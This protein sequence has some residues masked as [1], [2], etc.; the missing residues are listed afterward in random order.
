MESLV[1]HHACNSSLLPVEFEN[2]FSRKAS[3]LDGPGLPLTMSAGGFRRLILIGLKQGRLKA[4]LK[5][6]MRDSIDIFK[7][8]KGVGDEPGLG[9]QA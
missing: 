9:D 3:I 7:C 5:S 2:S 8:S 4:F 6:Q 1:G